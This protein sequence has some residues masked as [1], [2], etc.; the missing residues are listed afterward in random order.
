MN[1]ICKPLC[2]RNLFPFILYG[3]NQLS[4]CATG[5]ATHLD[6]QPKDILTIGKKG[7]KKTLQK[8]E[9]LKASPPSGGKF[10]Q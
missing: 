7:S 3:Q 5:L 10:V 6:S 1:M 4:S 2:K 9:W 8:P